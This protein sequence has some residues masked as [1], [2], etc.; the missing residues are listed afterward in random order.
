[1]I[2]GYS[3]KSFWSKAVVRLKQGLLARRQFYFLVNILLIA[4]RKKRHKLVICAMFKDEAK[5]LDEWIKFHLQEGVKHIYLYNDESTDE[6]KSVL[7]PWLKKGVVTLRQAKGRV[8]QEIFNHFIKK[9]KNHV[10]WIA[11]IDI[12]EFLH[13][14]DKLSLTQKL[15]EYEEFS[16]IFIFWQVFGGK[17]LSTTSSAGVIEDCRYT[18][19]HEISSVEMIEK[20]K[21]WRELRGSSRLTGNPI[22]GKS[23]VRVSSVQ[24]MGVHFPNEYIGK[25]S[26]VAGNEI[27]PK[28]VVQDC[29]SGSY[30]VTTDQIYINHYWGRSHEAIIQK[31]SQPGAS[32]EARHTGLLTPP[33][34]LALKWN[35]ILTESE[36]LTLIHRVRSLSFPY[37]FCI[38]FNKT[39]TTSLTH[40]FSQNGLPAVHWDSNK[41]VQKMIENVTQNQP[42]MSGYDHIYKVFTNMIL[43]DDSQIVEGNRFFREMSND[44]PN[45]YFILNNRPTPNWILSRS[46]HGKGN[47]LKRQLK[48]L[49]TENP[50]EAFSLWRHQKFTH[51]SE[52]RSFFKDNLRFLEVD[53]ENVNTPNIISKFLGIELDNSHW[54]TLNKTSV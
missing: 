54:L 22:Q 32:F 37:I 10:D 3:Y 53:I 39:G 20:W 4:K 52:V 7:E 50:E 2:N 11:F 43:A 5:Y 47:F 48:L 19:P 27:E 12:D 35:E 41:L 44:Y 13:T 18:L 45:S 38:G 23:L 28:S 14:R 21:T 46:L 40:F 16:G 6:Y 25:F 1:M 49:E 26:D 33:V 29:I 9:E 24:S 8:Q 30:T 42:I 31:F 15:Q 17:E 51:E 34:D 36:D